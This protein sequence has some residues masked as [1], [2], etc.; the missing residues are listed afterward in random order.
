MLISDF[1]ESRKGE[2]CD[3]VCLKNGG[4]FQILKKVA[5]KW[6][7]VKGKGVGKSVL[8]DLRGRLDGG[9]E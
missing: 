6:G 3:S 5:E 1:R 7:T 8:E 2:K 4:G 9:A